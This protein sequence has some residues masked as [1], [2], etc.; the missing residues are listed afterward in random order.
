MRPDQASFFFPFLD[1]VHFHWIAQW[2][3]PEELFRVKNG[4]VNPKND[5]DNN[6][7]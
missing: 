1:G 2:V 7:G 4:D 5:L 6:R 3:R